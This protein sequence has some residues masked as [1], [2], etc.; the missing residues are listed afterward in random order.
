M[1]TAEYVVYSVDH[2][3]DR[4]TIS[5]RRS[6]HEI[7][8]AGRVDV[9]LPRGCTRVCGSNEGPLSLFLDREIH[10]LSHCPVMV[11]IRF[12]HYTISIREEIGH[13]SWSVVLGIN[14]RECRSGSDNLS[15]RLKLV[16][17]R[18]E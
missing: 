5:D 11:H 7:G 12:C 3:S 14:D 16:L 17:I 10:V 8:H 6:L 4:V 9:L 13:R 15:S 18:Y 2:Y 1:L